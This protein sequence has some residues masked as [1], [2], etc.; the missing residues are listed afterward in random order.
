MVFLSARSRPW[1]DERT[2]PT[3]CLWCRLGARGKRADLEAWEDF[4]PKFFSGTGRNQDMNQQGPSN[5]WGSVASIFFRNLP[6]NLCFLFAIFLLETFRTF[7][8]TT[9]LNYQVNNLSNL[10]SKWCNFAGFGDFFTGELSSPSTVG[11]LNM[12]SYRPRPLF[13]SVCAVSV[14]L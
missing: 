1:C 3:W 13:Q 7:V 12:E 2:L 11:S 10:M 6:G 5:Y 14:P 4:L 8:K 9:K